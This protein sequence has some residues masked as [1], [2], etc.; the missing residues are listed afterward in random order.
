MKTTDYWL[1]QLRKACTIAPGWQEEDCIELIKRI[2][3]DRIVEGRRRATRN[4]LRVYPG[5]NHTKV[6]IAAQEDPEGMEAA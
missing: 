5:M 3:A 6:Q 1:K 2:Q 4:I